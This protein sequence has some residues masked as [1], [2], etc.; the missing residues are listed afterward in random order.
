MIIR[1]LKDL[2]E[3]S[4][5]EKKRKEV[6]ERRKTVT[7]YNEYISSSADCYELQKT[8]KGWQDLFTTMASFCNNYQK[9][10]DVGCGPYEL[11]AV[12]NDVNSVGVDISGVAL[13]I[14]KNHG[15]LGH[16]IQA[17][18][19]YLPFKD[20]SFD[21]LISNQVIE[22]MPSLKALNATIKEMLRVSRNLMIITPNSVFRRRIHDET[23]FFFFTVRDLK[24]YLPSFEIYASHFPPTQ[25]LRY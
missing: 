9:V 8:E 20:G 15:F 22:H 6:E 14:L 25:T 1:F 24:K 17:D 5:R 23:H 4:K 13:R 2:K 18:C 3:A 19:Q 21:C 7:L 12:K 10:L 11:I 16:V